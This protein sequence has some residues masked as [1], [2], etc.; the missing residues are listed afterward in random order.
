[1]LAPRSPHAHGHHLHHHHHEY[2]HITIDGTGTTS[3]PTPMRYEHAVLALLQRIHHSHT[4]RAVFREFELRSSHVAK[5][6][7][8]E[9]VFNAFAGADDL[10]HATAKGHVERSGKDGHVLTNAMGK[11]ILGLG[12]GSDSTI[13]FTPLTFS[14]YCSTGKKGHK[15]GA[16]PD[17][18]LFHEMVHAM[19]QMRGILDPLRSATCTTR[20]KSSSPS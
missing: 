1:M 11:P 4:G 8:L 14:N 18:V 6:I 5:V 9:G 20:R 17:E 13:Q 7:P 12:G 15:S 16:H 10:R 3:Y 2:N 19:R